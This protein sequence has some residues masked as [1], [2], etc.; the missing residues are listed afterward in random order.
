MYCRAGGSGP[1]VPAGPLRLGDRVTLTDQY[2]ATPGADGWCLG[3]SGEPRKTG[4]VLFAPEAATTAGAAAGTVGEQ[5]VVLVINEEDAGR[6]GIQPFAFRSSWLERAL[7]IGAEPPTST[8]TGA[9][10]PSFAQPRLFEVG[11]RVQLNPGRWKP[12]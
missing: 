11:D 6:P 1:V 7:P 5:R 3:K 12:R 8:T 9:P 4:I 2:F 10:L